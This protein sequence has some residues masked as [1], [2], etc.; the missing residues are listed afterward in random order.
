MDEDGSD[1]TRPVAIGSSARL[2][3][4]ICELLARETESLLTS[5]SGGAATD[6][7]LA[8]LNVRLALL[9]WDVLEDADGAARQAEL[10]ESH[11]YVPRL[12]LALA[13]TAGRADDLD[14]IQAMSE[15]LGEARRGAFLRDIAEAWLYR[16]GEVERA[17]ASARQAVELAKDATVRAD[18][19][20]VLYLALAAGESWEELGTALLDAATAKTT[21]TSTIAE[22]A[23]VLFDRS[24]DGAAA[25]DLVVSQLG[26]LKGAATQDASSALHA[27]RAVDI[28]LAAATA[29][30]PPSPHLAE[31]QA[32]KAAIL[33]KDPGAI[34]ELQCARYAIAIGSGDD[35]TADEALAALQADLSPESSLYGVRLAAIARIDR[36]RRRERWQDLATAL[37]ELATIPG[38]GE[39]A[40]SYQWRAAEVTDA[41]IGAMSAALEAWKGVTGADQH[42]Q[43]QRA[44]ERLLLLGEPSELATHLSKTA[45][46]GGAQCAAGRRAAAVIES[47]LGDIARAAKLLERADQAGDG[48]CDD[49]TI[50][51]ARREGN[52]DRLVARYGEMVQ[53]ETDPRIIAALACAGGAIHLSRGNAVEAEESFRMAARRAPNDP[54]ARAGLAMV[55]RRLERWRE[56]AAVLGEL[57]PLVTDKSSRLDILREQGR[58]YATK[59]NDS[60]RA[61]ETLE[62]ALAMDE[63]NAET[64]RALAELYDAARQWDKALELRHKALELATEPVAKAALWVEI[65]KILE[66]QKKDA[67]G[68]Q[69]A[70]ERARSEDSANVEALRALGQ[71]F[72]KSN[73]EAA[74]LDVLKAE[75]ATDVDDQRR[76]ALQLEIAKLSSGGNE[77]PAG[78][79][80][81]YLAALQTDPSNETALAGVATIGRKHKD[82]ASIA[83]AFR[84][85][86][87][88]PAN[89]NILSEALEEN[90]A[91]PELV[92]ALTHAVTQTGN[93]A[94]RAALHVRLAKIHEAHLDD[95][96]AA[97][98]AYQAALSIS[99]NDDALRELVRLLESRGQWADLASAYDQQLK[100]LPLEQADRQVAMLLRIAEMRRDKLGQPADAALSFEAVLDREPHHVPALMALEGLYEQLNRDKDLLRI[101]ATR[102][103][104]TED[105]AERGRLFGR[106]GNVRQNRG[107][108][109]E[110]LSAFQLAFSADP[111][112]RDNFTLIEKLCY[113]H[114]RWS[115]A[116]ALYNL[117]I[118][119]V[120]DGGSRAYRLGDLYARRGQVQLQYLHELGEAANS[121]LRV[122][123]L[124]PD[125]DTSIKFLESIFSQQSDWKGLIG[126]YEKRAGGA[127]DDEKKLETLRRAARVAA[128]KLKDN[129]EAARIYEQILR[130]Q[131][132]DTEASDALE[133]FYEGNENWAKLVDVLRI[134]LAG[135]PAGDAATALLRRIAQISEE[136]LRD[137]DKA[138]EHYVRILEIAPG[139]KEALDALGRIYESTEQWAEFIDVTRRQ[140]R[141]T[142]D[143]NVKALLYFKCGSVM[144]AKFG[145]EEDAIR[146]YDAAIKTSPSCLPAVHGLR[147]LYRR[148]EDWPRVIQTLELE[149]KLWQDDKERAGV[150]AQIGRIYAEYLGQPQKAMHYYESALAVDPECLPANKSLFEHY[151]A[152]A[153]WNRAQ[154][155]A[156]ALAQKAMREG[157]PSERS[158]FYRKRGVVSQMTGDPRSAAESLIIA[159][160]I[161]PTNQVS[162]DALG[163]LA[164]DYPEA[165]DFEAT[166]RELDKI[167]KRRDDAQPFLA[168]V[169]VAQA[170]MKER[171]GDLDAAEDLYN[172]A[173]KLAPREYEILSSLVELHTN[174]RRWTHAVDAIVN[175]LN[176]SP[177]PEN[178]VRVKALTHQA[179][180]H[181]ECEMDPHRATA[182]LRDILRLQPT[183][184]DAYYRLAQEQYVLGKFDEAKKAIDRVIELAAAP[185]TEVSPE[186]LARYYYYRGRIGEA[187]GDA[188]G[189]T[190]QYRRSN[191]YDPGYAPPA[192]ALARRFSEGGDQRQAESV[193][194]SAAHAAMDRAGARAAVPLQ[195]G[196]ARI[197]LAS[198]DRP[199]AI[200]AYRGILNV[201]PD[202]AADRVA[203]AEV[204]A[205]DDLGKAIGELKKVIERDIHHAPAYRLLAS[206]YSRI[207]END[208]AARVLSTMELLGFAEDADRAAANA[209]RNAAVRQPLRRPLEGEVRG[210]LLLTDAAREPVGEI[211]SAIAGEVTALFP[212]P[213]MGEN[214]VPVQ[215]I[216]DGPLKVALSEISRL[217][218]VEPE[219]YIGEA[220]PGGVALLAFPRRIMVIDKELLN[221]AEPARRFLIG[222]GMEVIRGGYAVLHQL[223]R[224][225]RAELGSLMRSLLLAE[226]DR[227]GP[228]NEFIRSLPKNGTKL[229]ERYAGKGR[230]T[231]TDEWIDGMLSQAKRAGLLACDDFG[232]ATRMIARLSGDAVAAL[233]PEGI[234]ALG[235]VLGGSD[236]VRY[237]LSDNYH[238]LR[239]VLSTVTP[240]G[241]E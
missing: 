78:A 214:L 226:D 3:E 167:Y 215:A 56:L 55:Y 47:R 26:K 70:F 234:V 224:R 185:G 124:D 33:A 111:S 19:E 23:H 43:V 181:A 12:R 50:R 44:C 83:V 229:I 142:T 144:E 235:A 20:H 116:M 39:F 240:Q 27:V 137:E 69:D 191:E 46:T 238:K 11:P 161:K 121:Y 80:G 81:A 206:F 76:V 99:T 77:D 72:R 241:A 156:Q 45:A 106:L 107:E 93:D 212:Q 141:V 183:N 127:R 194:I 16:F 66:G 117:A 38:A 7:R 92:E 48:S 205:V 103:E 120:E 132:A 145:K 239:E 98:D 228:T 227:A 17:V 82:F 49:E 13:L 96:D 157:D 61:R 86:P 199:A 58:L 154:P 79:I 187:S 168:R 148:R 115:D 149:V 233:G 41:R 42:P 211:F 134:R 53:R 28:A 131:P 8:D 231:D 219:V 178:D 209:A 90:K 133:R 170:V 31:L 237:Y 169:R 65:G 166:Y 220:V 225:Q 30:T 197:L 14:T 2:V 192:L 223:G 64:V 165:Y 37:K 139:N 67:K 21:A 4:E 104:A 87:R 147:D 140:I 153:D 57:S 128:A 135:A 108:I 9:S 204:Y 105:S 189:A 177:P 164:R 112:N 210:Q 179:T 36:Y 172:E 102:A 184:Q 222:W 150:F 95:P 175:F 24:G 218:G 202:G 125:N 91:Y 35:A 163:L 203:L 182:V 85:A 190:S 173:A 32:A 159:L 232:A 94:D 221:E 101:L 176:S 138:V 207:G 217:F 162:L 193:L 123:E 68:A 155:L 146:Y 136:G 54:A 89:I 130:I 63:S 15:G 22:A 119:A 171:E 51:I 188:R 59:L 18:I 158:D 180:I 75:L 186:H 236:L 97:I 1:P 88:T 73:S 201:E 160:E 151:F 152:A 62:Q 71:F 6:E 25:I 143:R 52:R 34:R 216:D 195:R 84:A 29:S 74:L 5:D 118:V 10:A 60:R 100:A 109:A 126:A 114:E 196:L 174:M 200:E 213:A 208:R 122:V 230:D 110:A 129:E 40:A 113:K 198:G